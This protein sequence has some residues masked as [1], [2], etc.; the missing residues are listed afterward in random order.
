[1]SD[2]LFY[3][4]GSSNLLWSTD[5]PDSNWLYGTVQALYPMFGA[6]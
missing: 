5:R 2:V 1:M 3:I 6:G 4:L